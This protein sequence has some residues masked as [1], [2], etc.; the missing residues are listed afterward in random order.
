MK[1]IQFYFILHG[2]LWIW[3]LL[4]VYANIYMRMPY[5]QAFIL[6]VLLH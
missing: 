2:K 6:M 5:V 3:L 1:V 4:I